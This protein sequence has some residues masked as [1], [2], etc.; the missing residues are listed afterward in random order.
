MST[1]K[2]C[3]LTALATLLLLELV[4]QVGSVIMWSQNREATR[5]ETSSGDKTVLCIGDSFTFGQGSSRRELS[6]PAQ[7]EDLLQKH[8]SPDW[9]VINAGY[10][11][12]NSRDLL[13]RI[14]GQLESYK[15]QFVYII[16]GV[17][18]QWTK[19]EALD[20][21]I[22]GTDET[23]AAGNSFRLELR[24]LR[25]IKWMY[26]GTLDEDS[27]EIA[28]PATQARLK[29]AVHILPALVGT[30]THST[31]SL[32]IAEDGRIEFAGLTLECAATSDTL[33]VFMPSGKTL[34]LQ[35]RLENEELVLHGP[36]WPEP[37]R[38][39]APSRTPYE[40]IKLAE[41]IE[42][43]GNFAT[44]LDHYRRAIAAAG[45]TADPFW[46]ASTVRCLTLLDRRDETVEV[47]ELLRQQYAKEGTAKW[48]ASLC[49]VLSTVGNREACLGEARSALQKFPDDPF[50]LQLFAWQSFQS[51][52]MQESILAMEKAVTLSEDTNPAMRRTTRY[53]LARMLSKHHPRRTIEVIADLYRQENAVVMLD[54]TI[55]NVKKFVDLALVEETL[56]RTDLT[57][58]EQAELLQI[59]RSS[60][61]PS[62]GVFETVESHLEQIVHL[63][64]ASGGTAVLSSYPW[65]NDQ[66]SGI[67]SRLVQRTQAGRLDMTPGFRA[68]LKTAAR[69]EFFVSDGHCNDRGYRLMAEAVF[70]DLRQRL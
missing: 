22:P 33:T 53:Q 70:E 38:L 59:F 47:I 68:A 48:A 15:P 45:D 21:S 29:P 46:Y 44:A 16:I 41:L 1:L 13:E 28:E 35:W 24:T 27:A 3:L 51:G 39:R 40:L 37:Q 57:A 23:V 64:T 32:S 11:G 26:G 5:R 12:R 10:P 49:T 65:Y 19:P 4:L 8:L 42:Y 55:H 66:M 17:N 6:Y 14:S 61:L 54:T 2:R 52:E 7:L 9:R 34:D 36:Q 18:D 69:S 58:E 62:T 25:M 20:L 56:P 30:W 50:I 63:V 31:M 67:H 60:Y 43:E